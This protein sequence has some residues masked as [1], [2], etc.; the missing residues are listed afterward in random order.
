LRVVGQRE[1]DLEGK[2]VSLSPDGRRLAATQSDRLCIYSSDTL[3]QTSCIQSDA[4]AQVDRGSFAWSPDGARLAFTENFA[5]FLIESD[6]WVLDAEANRLTDLT[7]DGN[8]RFKLG[9]DNAALDI[10]P[11]WSSDGATLLFSRTAFLGG[12]ATTSLYRMPANGG[13]PTRLAAIN[14]LPAT[15]AYSLFWAGEDRPIFYTVMKNKL[16]DNA[17]GVWTI[18]PDGSDARQLLGITDPDLG[19][20]FLME[21][22]ASGDKALILYF[23]AALQYATRDDTPYWAVLDIESGALTPL[24]KTDHEEGHAGGVRRAIFSPDGSKLLYTNVVLPSR[25][26]I[27]VRDVASTTDN[28]L[29]TLDEPCGWYADFG[30]GLDWAGDD[31]LFLTLINGSRGLLLTLGGE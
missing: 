30:Q 6:V 26:E 18:Q 2:L 8:H 4:V 28:I 25:C 1:V 12:D 11:A 24:Q 3:A 20:P 15:V 14:D 19:P 21:V 29:L 22:S 10:L 17:N 9:E 27:I 23:Q 13:E 31:T 7:D 5:R 16:T